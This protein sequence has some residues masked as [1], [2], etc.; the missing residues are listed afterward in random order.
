MKKH[1]PDIL[2]TILA[3]A[4]AALLI[5]AFYRHRAEAY[6]QAGGQKPGPT[7]GH[8]RHL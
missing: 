4:L 2:L 7:R 6:R 3:A 1:L 8:K 5:L